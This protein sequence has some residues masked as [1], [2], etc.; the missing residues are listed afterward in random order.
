MSIIVWVIVLGIIISFLIA[1][2]TSLSEV[3]CLHCGSENVKYC[4]VT[5]CVKC[6]DCGSEATL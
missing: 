3:R 1:I 2:C 6:K 4:D 5:K